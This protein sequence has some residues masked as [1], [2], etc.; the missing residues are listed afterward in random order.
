MPLTEQ[1]LAFIETFGYLHFP[2]LFDP[3]EVSWITREFD[4]SIQEFGGGKDH[5]GSSR[6]MFGGCCVCSWVMWLSCSMVL[7]VLAGE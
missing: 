4:L 3:D 2:A 6:T 7:G 5:D 1:Q